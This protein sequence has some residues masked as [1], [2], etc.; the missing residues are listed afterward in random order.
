MAH[1]SIG[2]DDS[3]VSFIFVHT[4][5]DFRCI[6]FDGGAMATISWCPM[7]SWCDLPNHTLIR[8]LAKHGQREPCVA[9][10][11]AGVHPVNTDMGD[12]R[13]MID[14]RIA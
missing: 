5:D 9:V 12:A 11:L 6:N 7:E 8:Q 3:D 13:V 10:F 14:R 1:G 2:S 4:A